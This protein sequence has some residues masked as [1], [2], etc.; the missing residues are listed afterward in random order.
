MVKSFTVKELLRDQG[1]ALS[2]RAV[3]SAAKVDKRVTVPEVNRPGLALGGYLEHFRAER[4]QIIGR[5]EHDYCSQ[6][7]PR[8][9]AANLSR[10]LSFP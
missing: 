9:L 7:E 4:I 2:L 8:R 10:M 1:K 6:A 3:G 5:G